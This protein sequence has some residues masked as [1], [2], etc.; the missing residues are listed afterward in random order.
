MNILFSKAKQSDVKRKPILCN[1]YEA[2]AKCLNEYNFEQQQCLK[3]GLLNNH[4]SWAFASLLPTNPP[5]QYLTT[6]FGNVPKGC[7]FRIKP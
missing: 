4:P 3:K 5:T 1:L 2:C 6:P 7:V